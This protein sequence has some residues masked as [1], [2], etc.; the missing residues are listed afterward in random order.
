MS[1]KAVLVELLWVIPIKGLI[2]IS[3]R[4]PSVRSVVETG[5]ESVGAAHP[6]IPGHNHRV[7]DL[8]VAAADRK[9]GAPSWP[10]GTRSAR[11]A[12]RGGPCP[13]RTAVLSARPRRTGPKGRYA[14]AVTGR[15]CE[16]GGT[17]PAAG[18]P[19]G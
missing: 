3:V 4:T 5:E 12:H 16:G 6:C 14:S 7:T 17:A 11:R 13:A 2:R 8:P 1:V 10:K 9:D 19:A 15:R 18:D